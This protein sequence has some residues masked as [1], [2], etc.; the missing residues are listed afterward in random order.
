[1]VNCDQNGINKIDFAR[2]RARSA[3][4][5]RAETEQTQKWSALDCLAHEM[6]RTKSKRKNGLNHELSRL[7][8]VV[9]VCVCVAE[10]EADTKTETNIAY[11]WNA[12]W[13]W[14]V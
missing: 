2:C 4:E 7:Y 5:K 9:R 12:T 8:G 11:K 1:M 6:K 10:P 13:K 3:T 14:Q